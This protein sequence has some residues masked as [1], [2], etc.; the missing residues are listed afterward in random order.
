MHIKLKY[1][2][3]LK[4]QTVKC[5]VNSHVICILTDMKFDKPPN[6]YLKQIC[7][8][9]QVSVCTVTPYNNLFP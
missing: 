2:C 6:V 1:S 8:G 4:L 3:L 5:H 9:R 7:I